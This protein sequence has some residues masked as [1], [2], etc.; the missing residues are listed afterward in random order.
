MIQRSSISILK[1][2]AGKLI[3]TILS[4]DSLKAKVARGGIW[5]GCGSFLEQAARFGRNIL[6]ARLL[7]P[8]AFGTMALILSACAA[9]GALTEIGIKE[10][11]IRNPQ[12]SEERYI[13][14][15]WWLSICRAGLIYPFLFFTAPLFSDVYGIPGLTDP[16]RVAGLQHY[17][18]GLLAQRLTLR[19]G[20]WS[21]SGGHSLRT[22]AV[23]LE[24]L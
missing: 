19:F 17:S 24:F 12:G 10:G 4:G 15:A 22:G 13:R 3:G 14:T 1:S 20:I 6:L 16:L 11:L 2:C 23:W 18:M 5:L 21:S 7:V 8:E 9:I